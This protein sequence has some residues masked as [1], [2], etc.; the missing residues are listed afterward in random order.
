MCILN[1]VYLKTIKN[2]TAFT[3][4]EMNNEQNINSF[5][6]SL[7]NIW[8]TYSSKYLSPSETHLLHHSISLFEGISTFM[9][10]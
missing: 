2:E 10:Y 1:C 8:Y 6:N 7:H 4:T 9:G 5:Q 3:K